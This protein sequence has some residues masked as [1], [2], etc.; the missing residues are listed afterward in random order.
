[1]TETRP[2]RAMPQ[3][4]Q[5]GRPPQ[6]VPSDLRQ[7]P[8]GLPSRSR[9]RVLWWLLP[10]GL[11]A[12]IVLT[13]WLLTR[14]ADATPT[15][16][17][18]QARTA[19]LQDRV[20]AAALVAYPST[21]TAELRSPV[22]GTLTGVHV[23]EGD[24]PG[25]LAVVAEVNELPLVVLP[26]SVPLYRDLVEDLEGADVQAL[27][28]ALGAAGY[29]PGAYDGVFDDQTVTAVE[30]W[31]AAN[32]FEETGDMRLSRVLW[33]P[34]GG[35]I[36]AVAAR[37][38]DLAGAG[39]P[40]ASVAVPD[41]LVVHVALDQADVARV[42]A[43]DAVEVELDALDAPLPGAVETV[44]LTPSDDGTYQATVKLTQR[45]DTVR[46]GMEGTARVLV[47]LRENVVVVP[48]GAIAASSSTPTVRVV[49]DGEAQVREVRLGLVTTEG[50]E[51]LEG[52]APG[53][54]VVVGEQG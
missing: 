45:P 28:E 23:R 22:G 26:S 1:M 13:A 50:A 51:I 52:V 39:T 32:G 6:D 37:A 44:A 12:A 40:L 24:R 27:E 29:D 5:D 7:R 16:L 31:E 18:E 48:S 38:G 20:E 10:L 42:A 25:P 41:G 35:Q 14:D 9:R 21:A 19:S 11:L 3:D 4:G 46:V 34:P 54:A 8:Q 15:Y 33:I 36:T 17:T 43:G 30:A 47:D 53:D 49:V 2:F